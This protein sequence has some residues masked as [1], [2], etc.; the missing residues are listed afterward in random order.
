MFKRSW[1]WMPATDNW[2]TIFPILSK[3]YI[4]CLKRKKI[5]TKRPWKA[6][7]KNNNF[8][9]MIN[10]DF[11]QHK[12]QQKCK[13]GRSQFL[14]LIFIF[15]V[16][17]FDHFYQHC[18]TQSPVLAW[19]NWSEYY[20]KLVKNHLLCFSFF[21]KTYPNDLL[22]SGA[23]VLKPIRVITTWNQCHKKTYCM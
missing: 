22:R 2:W 10:L 11:V 8:L 14:P 19:P 17:I 15:E 9:N 12:K 20:L 6:H 4:V 1:V 16:F 23:D 21:R 18:H 7:F 3:F 5:N 13:F